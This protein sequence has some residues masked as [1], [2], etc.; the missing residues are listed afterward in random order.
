MQVG[1]FCFPTG[2]GIDIAEL[3]HVLDD[4]RAA[5][6]AGALLEV[7]DLNRCEILRPLDNYNPLAAAG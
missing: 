2:Y 7:P 6:I 4:Y 1:V 3:A 5:G